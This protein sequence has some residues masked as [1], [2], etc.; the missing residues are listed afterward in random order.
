VLLIAFITAAW[1]RF[2]E[3]AYLRFLSILLIS[4]PCAIGIAAPTAESS[5]LNK[6]AALGVVIRNR[7]VLTL[8]GKETVVIFDKTGTVTEGKYKVLSDLTHLETHE[9]SALGGL[10]SESIHPAAIACTLAAQG[11][12]AAKFEKRFEL[13]GQG[14]RGSLNGQEYAL[15]SEKFMKDLG[16][17]VPRILLGIVQEGLYS[18]VYFSRG[19]QL[20][21]SIA[22][23]DEI[24]PQ[25][26]KI[27][28]EFK[29]DN[30]K[31]ILLSG[32]S[33]EPVK[34]VA[35]QLGFDEWHAGMSPME[36][37]EL[38]DRL[39]KNS[40]VV[41]MVGDGINDAP[42]LT[43][44]N[45][46]IS[47]VTASEMSIQ[48]SDI[49]LTTPSLSTLNEMRKLAK[50]GQWIVREN[51]FWAFIFNVIGIGLAVF[52][53]LTPIFAAAAMSISSLVVL[54]NAKRL[55]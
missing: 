48:V 29:H 32:D 25:F 30:V 27:L 50:K 17:V 7:G 5:L 21:A 36:K 38:V 37:R 4:C 54:F 26:S 41:C 40:H 13:A 42:C 24:K 31:T 6:L 49:L 22:L 43:A 14:L 46:G 11:H 39:R 10:A 33:V 19:D 45:I 55:E 15:G 28:K 52:G 47:V 2:D 34:A 9:L 51:L 12:M 53:L 1:F 35:T 16:I 23:G 44:A 20:L 18:T 3:T 8:L